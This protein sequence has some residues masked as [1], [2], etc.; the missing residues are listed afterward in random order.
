MGHDLKA[1]HPCNRCY[2]HVDPESDGFNFFNPDTPVA[3]SEKMLSDCCN[4]CKWKDDI[5]SYCSAPG[6]EITNDTHGIAVSKKF[7]ACTIQRMESF[8]TSGST[9]STCNDGTEK[10]LASN[11]QLSCDDIYGNG[12]YCSSEESC[13]TGTISDPSKTT[14]CTSPFK[15][16]K[17]ATSK[18]C[19]GRDKKDCSTT[20][21]CFW[22]KGAFGEYPS[23]KTGIAGEAC[24]TESY[25]HKQGTAG[26]LNEVC[27][28][29][30]Y[31]EDESILGNGEPCNPLSSQC[32]EGLKCNSN[33]KCGPIVTTG[34]GRIDSY[35]GTKDGKAP[36]DSLCASGY[37]HADTFRCAI[38]PTPT[39]AVTAP[40][41]T[42]YLA[43][44]CVNND[45]GTVT[46][47][48]KKPVPGF[49][50]EIRWGNGFTESTTVGDRDQ[51]DPISGF[52]PPGSKV[53]YQIR[54]YLGDTI[55]PFTTTK[56]FIIPKSCG[57]VSAPIACAGGLANCA[58]DTGSN[59]TCSGTKIYIGNTAQ[60]DW[61]K[62]N[63]GAGSREYCWKCTSS[64]PLVCDFNKNGSYDD[65]DITT[66]TQGFNSG[67]TQGDCNGDGKT[68]IFDYN[69][70]LEKQLP[71]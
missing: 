47:Q 70:W 57:V 12:F 7:S 13:L 27:Y 38:R 37:C 58:N 66:W 34:T 43:L 51:S 60:D 42:A 30:S 50:Y 45:P 9:V 21:G 2:A 61:C 36:D 15:C 54:A 22:F 52:S 62:K 24:G 32:G 56:E 3:V 40:V 8:F 68:T 16:C 1:N 5:M 67:T 4:A 69:L 29:E 23:C 48:W 46:F 49:N 25:C 64:T 20:P 44:T 14:T 10:Y 63:G 53:P 39:P 6:K 31:C 33:N 65:G 11:K 17:M 18:P 28:F 35:C 41:I 19:E 55:G 71:A 26:H 59:Y